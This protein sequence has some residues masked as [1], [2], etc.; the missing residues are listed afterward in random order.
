MKALILD[1]RNNPG[2]LLEQADQV[3]EQFVPNGHLIVSTEGRGTDP[4]TEY[5]A[6][7]RGKRIDLPMV[8]L[9]NGDSASAAEIVAGCLQD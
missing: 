3:C 4:Q 9:V 6:H 5:L 1:L 8:V 7:S 2:G